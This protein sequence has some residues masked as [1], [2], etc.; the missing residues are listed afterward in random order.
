MALTT[1]PA[2]AQ[3]AG[4]ARP[5][6]WPMI[7]AHAPD[8]AIEA[9]IDALLAAMSL[10]QKV[11]QIIQGDIGSTTPEDVATYHLGS[12]L[13]GGSSSPGGDEFGPASA[14]V[15]AA[16]AYYD[17]SM[18]P[19]GKLPRIPVMWGSDAVH[20]HNNIVGA[21]LFPHNI[22]LGAARNPALMEQIGAITAIEMRVTGLDWTFAPTIAVA[23]DDRWGRTYESFGEDPAIATSYATALVHG[24]QGRRGDKDWLKGPHIIATAKHF[25]ADGGTADGRDRGDAKIDEAELIRLH[26]PAYVAALNA[27]VQSVMASFSG[28]NSVKMHGNASLLTGVLKRRWGFDGLVVGD[29][30][31][32]AKVPGCT[33]ADCPASIAAGLD[34]YMGPASWKGLYASTLAAGQSGKL[35][36]ARLDDAVRRIL[37]VKLRAGLFEAG[38][39]STRAY[40]GRYELLGAPD[41]RAVARAAVRESLVLL[42]NDGVLPLKPGA[43]ILVAGDGADNVAK[44]SGGWTLTWQGTGTKP[45][46]FPGATSIFAGVRDAVTV[47]GGTA[48]LSADGRFTVKPDAAIVVFGEDPYAEFQGD[49]ADLYFDDTRGSLDTMKRLKAA[50]IPVVAVFLSGR[51]LWVNR[52][53]NAAGAFVAAWLPG[54]E[55]GGVADVLFGKADFKGKLPFSWPADAKGAPLNVGDPGYKPLYPFGY[56]LK[57]ADRSPVAALS[58]DPAIVVEQPLTGPIFARG[59]PIGTRLLQIDGA[60]DSPQAISGAADN[61]AIAVRPVDR[62]AQEDAREIAWPGRSRGTL[63]VTNPRAADLSSAGPLALTLDLRVDQAPAGPATLEI[64][65]GPG[66]TARLDIA[67]RLTAIAGQGWQ[68]LSIPLACLPGA[69]LDHITAPFALSSSAPMRLTL[70][71]IA[72]TPVKETPCR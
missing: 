34:M 59:R 67:D 68:T 24:L 39:P 49:R 41:H 13:N 23:R 28:W 21:T 48:T 38:K 72:L 15:T 20:G 2:V 1:G 57:L 37:R 55:G 25:L 46:H 51:P 70:S 19:N 65:C 35:P 9:R 71:S 22:G 61:G 6:R 47:G 63:I 33:P 36:M 7:Q 12:I 44:Q 27:D 54:S 69:K 64:R 60:N 16:D 56:G 31:G 66:C 17:A 26:A 30:D 52:H 29:W 10:E 43:R 53:I 5:D 18:R 32:H 8:T 3:D 40:A 4:V 50:G 45:E 62:D 58:E 42:K 11:G 14:W